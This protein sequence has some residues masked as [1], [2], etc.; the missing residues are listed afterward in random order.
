M[1]GL[2]E[3]AWRR[4]AALPGGRTARRLLVQDWQISFPGRPC[5]VL[6][7]LGGPPGEAGHRPSDPAGIKPEGLAMGIAQRSPKCLPVTNW[8]K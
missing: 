6:Q 7:L 1:D 8:P 4:L 5:P 2:G 3:N